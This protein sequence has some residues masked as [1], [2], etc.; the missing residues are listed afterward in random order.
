[1]DEEP[2]LYSTDLFVTVNP[3]RTYTRALHDD[4]AR[5]VADLAEP[6]TAQLVLG[7]S[8]EHPTIYEARIAPEEVG[9]ELSTRQRLFHAHFLFELTHSGGLRLGPVADPEGVGIQRRLQRYFSDA[10]GVE[11]VYVHAR[12]AASSAAK[13]Y[14]R[15]QQEARNA[16]GAQG[17]LLPERTLTGRAGAF[18]GATAAPK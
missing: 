18:R 13:N 12:L 16:E 9:W 11:G 7:Q 10:L 3:H 8:S 17:R 6:A 2:R 5:A 1:M 15:K 14:M 4:F